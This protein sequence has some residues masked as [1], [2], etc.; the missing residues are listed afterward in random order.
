MEKKFVTIVLRQV[1]GQVEEG[2]ESPELVE[3]VELLASLARVSRTDKQT[4]LWVR[5]AGDKRDLA[6][7]LEDSPGVTRIRAEVLVTIQE[8]SGG[9]D[10]RL[11]RECLLPLMSHI[12]R[13]IKTEP[14]L[15]AVLC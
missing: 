7:C 2:G 4:E 10:T 8:M 11:M 1:L 5:A 14:K 3:M 9:Q 15:A 13:S 12:A 6:Q